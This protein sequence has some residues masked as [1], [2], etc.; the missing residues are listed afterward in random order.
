MF[1]RGSL[2]QSAQSERRTSQGS[3]LPTFRS[4]CIGDNYLGVS[5]ANDWLSPIKGTSLAL[6]GMELDLAEFIPSEQ[7]S[8][9]V[10][11]SYQ[12]FLSQAFNRSS[13]YA[14]VPPPFQYD[15]VYTYAEWYLRSINPFTPILHK[16][17]FMTLLRKF[18]EDQHFQPSAAE[19]VMVHM[20]LA[21]IKFQYSARNSDEQSRN[22]SNVHYHYALSFFHDLMAGHTLQ[23]V[24]ALA[25]IC[26]HLRN[27][28]RPGP[29]WMVT[30]MALGLAIELGLHRSV[31]AWQ[32][33][34]SEK[35][36][37]EAEM[38]KRVFWSLMV[39]HVTLS[40]KLGRPMPLHLEDFDVEIPEPVF[41]N[42]PSESNM[43]KWRKCSFRAGIQGF[44][45][46][47]VM[48]QVYST[49]YSIRS[50]NRSYEATVKQL[51]R[52]VQMFQTQ[53]P[54]EL[55]GGNQ[56]HQEDR[57]FAFYIQSSVQECQLL[58]HHPALCR[59]TAPQVV[60]NNTDLCL[61]ASNKLLN[62]AS[63]LS[64]LKSLDTTW[65][66]ATLYLAAVFT[67]LFVYTER[68]DQI[69]ST[70]LNSLKEDMDR[71]L[72]VMGEVGNL[73]GKLNSMTLSSSN[74]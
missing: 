74:R 54:P 19:T 13:Q 66:N 25:L 27:F 2:S 69:T 10:A 21:I 18:A 55:A 61:D 7:D 31:K 22:A 33:S 41:D 73:L 71:W 1:T 16:P 23:D 9:S 3:L 70:D 56:T 44:K 28:P 24:Q 29:A 34:T 14:P 51:E 68:K 38:R 39:Y 6:F 11:M 42:L 32:G 15:E 64:Y 48:M 35:G 20:V 46:L 5:S 53:L 59:S 43:S 60:A 17:D 62:Y 63:Q 30:N 8:A 12:T 47:V 45:L 58:L 52:E 36:A 4:G 37:H 65:H 26:S 72:E 67:T 57:I 49:I 40:G 50:N